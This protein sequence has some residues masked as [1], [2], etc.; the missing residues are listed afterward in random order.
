MNKFVQVSIDCK[1]YIKKTS[2]EIEPYAYL[3]QVM[4]ENFKNEIL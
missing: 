1:D 3:H 4:D 2:E